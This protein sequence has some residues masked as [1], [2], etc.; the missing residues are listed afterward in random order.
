MNTT[1]HS[2]CA[3]VG[4]RWEV[5]VA[6]SSPSLGSAPAPDADAPD[7]ACLTSPTV[8]AICHQPLLP[9][10]ASLAT[11]DGGRVHRACAE[12]EAAAAWAR[13]RCWAHA[14][15]LLVTGSAL[16]LVLC[17]APREWFVLLGIVAFMHPLVHRRCWHYR[18]RVVFGCSRQCSK[19]RRP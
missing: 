6:R 10:T 4:L 18:L 13:R 7:P 14:H 8:C 2:S 16:A 3:A 1:A 5:A 12:R 17:D 11:R 15:A 9:G 19:E